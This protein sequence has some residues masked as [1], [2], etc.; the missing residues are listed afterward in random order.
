MRFKKSITTVICVFMLFGNSGMSNVNAAS[1]ETNIS[2][3]VEATTE[4]MEVTDTVTRSETNDDS[5]DMTVNET[6]EVAEES[7]TAEDSSVIDFDSEI[8]EIFPN[9][10][11]LNEDLNDDYISDD[12]TKETYTTHKYSYDS[13]GRLIR[14]EEYY[15]SNINS[16]KEYSYDSNG[17]TIRKCITKYATSG[18][19]IGQITSSYEYEYATNGNKKKLVYKDFVYSAIEGILAE[20]K[21]NVYEF[22]SRGFCTKAT[23][24]YEHK[25][26]DIHYIVKSRNT[27]Q[28]TDDGTK[29]KASLDY[30]DDNGHV[31]CNL[32]YDFFF[33]FY[34]VKQTFYRSDGKID[35]II[36]WNHKVRDGSDTPSE[37]AMYYFYLADGGCKT[38]EYNIDDYVLTNS[39]RYNADGTV[40]NNP[41]YD[42]SWQDSSLTPGIDMYRLY[43]PNS[44]EHFYTADS[45]ERDFLVGVGWNYEGIGWKAPVKSNTPVYRL[46]NPNAGDHHYTM[47]VGERDWLVS[48]GWNYEGI[49]W[50]SDDMKSV[51]LYRQYNPNAETGSHNYTTNKAENDWLVSVGWN[52]EG[53][54]WY[55]I[56]SKENYKYSFSEC[57][58]KN[59]YKDYSNV[60]YAKDISENGGEW[61]DCGVNMSVNGRFLE[62]HNC[63]S[64]TNNTTQ[65]VLD[66]G[67]MHY[68]GGGGFPFPAEGYYIERCKDC[69]AVRKVDVTGQMLFYN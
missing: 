60:T 63:P 2:T 24:F 23:C 22:D 31:Y 13:N 49:G 32:T 21:N 69:G 9:D 37:R 52:A 33:F 55:G 67:T 30:Y 35:Y 57:L 36:F 41:V 6:D 15:D 10:E 7:D 38:I 20:T 54:G 34:S 42:E 4:T 43:N 16:V 53:I 1:L 14:D 39:V 19:E 51:P 3:E 17:N 50:Y 61:C 48:L 26:E 5:E 18:K 29:T 46:Y 11:V 40:N 56:V 68:V 65:E 66:N 28:Y 25:Y 27:Y 12:L 8:T 59:T 62:Y 64:N 45:N 47:S 44:G 58:H